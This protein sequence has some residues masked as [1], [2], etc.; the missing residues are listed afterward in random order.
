MNYEN[1]FDSVTKQAFI[2]ALI[3]QGVH[4]ADAHNLQ[5]TYKNATALIQIM[6][7]H[8]AMVSTTMEQN[9]TFLQIHLL[10]SGIHV[11]PFSQSATTWEN[12][13]FQKDYL[14]VSILQVS[15]SQST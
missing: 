4:E 6:F 8:M 7:N 3:N 5:L 14:M 10:K 9:G 15:C 1:A 12:A 11:P 13:L 2:N